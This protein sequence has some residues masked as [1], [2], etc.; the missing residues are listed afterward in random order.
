MNEPHIDIDIGF[1]SA[2]AVPGG[3]T[4]IGGIRAS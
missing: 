2:E 4:L 1:E 3:G